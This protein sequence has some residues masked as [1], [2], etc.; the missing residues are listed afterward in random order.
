MKNE[1]DYPYAS[2]NNLAIVAIPYAHVPYSMYIILPNERD[3]I[4]AI[5][6]SLTGDQ[7]ISF[8]GQL[9]TRQ[10][11]LKFP[12]FTMRQS[13]PLKKLL[14]DLGLRQMFQDG[15]DFSRMADGPMKVDDAVHEAYIKVDSF[16]NWMVSRRK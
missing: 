7:L 1:E 14:Q 5:E 10:V 11:K 13:L 9:Q 2:T 4:K 15:A 12:K 3:G 6:Q 16:R 8:L